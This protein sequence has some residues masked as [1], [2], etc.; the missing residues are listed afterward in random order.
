MA[1]RTCLAFESGKCSAFELLLYL[2]ETKTL[3]IVFSTTS[4]KQKLQMWNLIPDPPCQFYRKKYV[5]LKN[6]LVFYTGLMKSWSFYFCHKAPWHEFRLDHQSTT[7]LCNFQFRLAPCLLVKI[8]FFGILTSIFCHKRKKNNRTRNEE[9]KIHK[10]LKG[11][12]Q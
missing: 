1:F 12:L 6:Y 2:K 3:G 9:R 8:I 4:H 5:E 10:K 7:T 11:A